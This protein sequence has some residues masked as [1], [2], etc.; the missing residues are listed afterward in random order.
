MRRS[1]MR[2]R[3]AVAVRFDPAAR[4]SRSSRH[5]RV[6]QDAPIEP[7]L[8]YLARVRH[9]E[10]DAGRRGRELHIELVAVGGREPQV[11]GR[12]GARRVVVLDRATDAS[13]RTN[14]RRVA[15]VPTA[16]LPELR[17]ADEVELRAFRLEVTEGEGDAP[18]ARTPG[19]VTMARGAHGTGVVADSHGA[20]DAHR[21]LE[22]T[23]GILLR[24]QVVAGPGAEHLGRGGR[25][26][27]ET[28]RHE[29]ARARTGHDA[30]DALVSERRCGIAGLII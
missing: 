30:Y 27:V 25:G 7:V 2:S 10:A 6:H 24:A 4:R 16:A 20:R 22:A 17:R 19:A 13:H 15:Q 1:L 3:H 11:R 14:A 23:R 5:P 21:L 18:V 8:G 12:D 29:P 26:Q 28:D 9:V